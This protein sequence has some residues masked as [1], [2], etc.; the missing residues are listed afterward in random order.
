MVTQNPSQRQNLSSQ[1]LPSTMVRSM[2]TQNSQQPS[3]RLTNIQAASGSNSNMLPYIQ[4]QE[5]NNN[6]ST[7]KNNN[8][9]SITNETNNNY[10]HSKKEGKRNGV[11]LPPP[12]SFHYI[13]EASGDQRLDLELRSACERYKSTKSNYERYKSTKPDVR[14]VSQ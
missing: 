4:H 8:N 3:I 6:S 13:L 11:Q 7:N 14:K 9:Q 12:F 2:V 10:Y 1:R 5:L